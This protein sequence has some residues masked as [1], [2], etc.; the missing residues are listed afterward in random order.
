MSPYVNQDDDC[1]PHHEFGNKQ[2]SH[3]NEYDQPNV[4][5]VRN[6]RPEPIVTNQNYA[7]IV[8]LTCPNHFDYLVLLSIHLQKVFHF[9]T[10][11]ITGE[12]AA[13]FLFGFR[14]YCYNELLSYQFLLVVQHSP[15]VSGE[16]HRLFR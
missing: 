9:L 10:N 13:A 7:E 16:I 3:L 6:N 11:L 1:C 4:K 5:F 12:G 2:A 8:Q 14:R 15:N